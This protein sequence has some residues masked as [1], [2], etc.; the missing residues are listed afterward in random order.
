MAETAYSVAASVMRYFFIALLAFIL[1]DTSVR[2]AVESARMKRLKKSAGLAVRYIEIVAPSLYAGRLYCVDGGCTIGSDP[3]CGVP[4][5]KSEL[6]GE[7]ARIRI[8]RG[9]AVFS[10]RKRRFSEINGVKPARR[11]VLADGDTV[12]I[13]DVS[14]VCHRKKGGGGRENETL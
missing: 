5:V 10:T 12:W 9:A 11:T 14:F 1:I 13:K 7:H 8:A 3:A 4:L 6:A 2:C